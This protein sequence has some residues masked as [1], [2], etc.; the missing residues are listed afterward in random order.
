MLLTSVT[1]RFSK[2]LTILKLHN[3][4]ADLGWPQVFYRVR[5]KGL[6]PLRA[7]DDRW[8]SCLTAVEQDL[9]VFAATDEMA[10]TLEIGDTVPAMRV[11]RND[12]SSGNA[13]VQDT[14]AIVFQ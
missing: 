1:F 10:A 2:A 12:V 7:R 14:H 3:H 13:R 11:E 6:Q 8:I 5:R 4:D 9:A